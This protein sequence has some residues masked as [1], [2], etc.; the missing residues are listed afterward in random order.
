MDPIDTA[1]PESRAEGAIDTLGD[2]QVLPFQT[3]VSAS[4]VF[5]SAPPRPPNRTMVLPCAA[6]IA[7]S[8]AGGW[9]VMCCDQSEP[10]HVQVSASWVVAVRPPNIT[11]SP[12][13]VAMAG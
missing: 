7:A 4:S 5:P 1:T 12:P 10:F 13:S 9:A 2:A 8:R 11:T 3:Q 6:I